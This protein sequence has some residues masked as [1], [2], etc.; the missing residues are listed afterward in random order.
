MVPYGWRATA[1][2]SEQK[3]TAAIDP[4]IDELISWTIDGGAE[5]LQEW[6]DPSADGEEIGDGL[7]LGTITSSELE[8]DETV[9]RT[10]RQ[11]AGAYLNL[12]ERFRAPY[13][14]RAG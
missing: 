12:G 8:D 14:D 13:F 5:R 11:L 1:W 6:T 10:A 2:L 7:L 9:R 3:T 4:L